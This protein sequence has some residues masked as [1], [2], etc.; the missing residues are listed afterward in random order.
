MDKSRF[1]HILKAELI[2][3][4]FP[5]Y[6]VTHIPTLVHPPFLQDVPILI[7]SLSSSR[8]TQKERQRCDTHALKSTLKCIHS[9]DELSCPCQLFLKRH[10]VKDA[11]EGK[12]PAGIH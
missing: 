8:E 3:D 7:S 6:T 4:C 10:D 1:L 11:G 2:T 5:E 9:Y 12:F